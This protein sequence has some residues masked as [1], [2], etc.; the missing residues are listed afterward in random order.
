MIDNNGVN[1]QTNQ[2]EEVRAVYDGEVGTVASIPGLNK[3]VFIKHGDYTTVY[4]K[5][6]KVTVKAGQTVKANQVLGEVYTDKNG[7]SE[8][9]FQIWQNDKKLN[10]QVW[11][12]DK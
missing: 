2:G 4:A 5:L 11:L 3:I 10:P 12:N 1:I 9:Q 8:L 6:A 7:T